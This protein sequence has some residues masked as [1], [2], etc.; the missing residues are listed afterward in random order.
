MLFCPCMYWSSDYIGWSRGGGAPLSA[1]NFYIFMQFSG[2]IGQIIGWR[3]REIMDP[4]LD[5]PWCCTYPTSRLFGVPGWVHS[6]HILDNASWT[7]HESQAWRRSEFSKLFRDGSSA[8]VLFSPRQCVSIFSI[9]A[10]SAKFLCS[11]IKKSA[12]SRTKFFQQK[13]ITFNLMWFKMT[14]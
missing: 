2:K 14:I 1:Q 9:T 8:Q 3:P 5:Y 13:I 12:L 6:H 10:L 11:L 4:P 7:Q